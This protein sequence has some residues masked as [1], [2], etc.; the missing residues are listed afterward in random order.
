MPKPKKKCKKRKLSYDQA[1][2]LVHT[3]ALAHLNNNKVNKRPQ[4]HFYYCRTCQF[5]HTT[6]TP[7]PH[8]K[9]N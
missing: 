9:F 1:E 3:S 5:W 6:T 2:R 7:S 4:I 8:L